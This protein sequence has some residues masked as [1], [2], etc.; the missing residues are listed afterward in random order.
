MATTIQ[1]FVGTY[2]IDRTHS[3]VQFAIR[4][5]NVSTFRASF[6]H[7][8]GRLAVEEDSI[9]LEAQARVESVS[10]VEPAFRDHVV[11][12]MDFFGADAHPLATF[13]STS[14]VLEDGGSAVVAGE[15]TIRD[16]THPVTAVGTYQAPTQDPFGVH[17]AGLE[18]RATIDRRDWA[19]DW[20]APLP[21]GADALGWEVDITAHL[22]LTRQL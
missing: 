16:V 3:T 12:G 20:Q 4:H 6:G 9:L 8:D 5:L 21:D 15:L 18:L 2:D 1:A 10:I 7:V 19:M 14:V 22:E 13:R 11:R 17:R